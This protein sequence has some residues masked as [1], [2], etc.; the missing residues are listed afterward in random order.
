MARPRKVVEVPGQETKTDEID[1]T[2]ENSLTGTATIQQVTETANTAAELNAATAGATVITETTM[3]TATDTTAPIV[4][5]DPGQG[6]FTAGVTVQQKVGA[7]LDSTA[8]AERNT[9][10]S[11]LPAAGLEIITRFEAYGFVDEV[12]HPLTNSLDFL[13]L[14]KKATTAPLATVATL[15]GRVGAMVVNED[16]TQHAAPGKPVLT[17]D[18]WHIP[19]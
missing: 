6:D 16:G 5:I 2:L 11:T 10:L 17:K 8:L 13:D 15:R 12:G 14:V 4:G 1:T 18:G 3:A 19:G 9:M 7:L